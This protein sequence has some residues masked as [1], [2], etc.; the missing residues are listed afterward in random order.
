MVLQR[1]EHLIFGAE[2]GL[3]VAEVIGCNFKWLETGA[4]ARYVEEM[5]LRFVMR[6]E[7]LVMVLAGA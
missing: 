6:S 7:G 5:V 1:F 4:T 3:Q 2:T